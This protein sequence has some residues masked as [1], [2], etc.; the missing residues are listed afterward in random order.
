MKKQDGVL[1]NVLHKDLIVFRSNPNKLWE[2]VTII[3]NEAFK[4]VTDIKEIEIPGMVKEIGIRAFYHC[5]KLEKLVI[6]EGLQTIK[7]AAFCGCE[8]LKEVIL[9]EGIKQIDNTAFCACLRLE[10]I[11]VPSTVD[12]IS[13]RL[14]CNCWNLKKIILSQGLLKIGRASFDG[15]SKLENIEIPST[16]R[17]IDAYAFERCSKLKEIILPE[18]LNSIQ[19]CV[20]KGCTSLENVSIPESVTEIHEDAFAD[21]SRLKKMILP[22]SLKYINIKAFHN[23]NNMEE[24]IIP[25]NIKSVELDFYTNFNFNNIKYLSFLDDEDLTHPNGYIFS[26]DIPQNPH[27]IETKRI[28]ELVAFSCYDDTLLYKVLIEESLISLHDKDINQYLLKNKIKLPYDIVNKLKSEYRLD[29]FMKTTNFKSFRRIQKMIPEGL[30]SNNLSTFYT[31]AYNIGCFSKDSNLSNQA[32]TWLE[33]RLIS[34]RGKKPDLLFTEMHSKFASIKLKGENKEFSEFL[35]GKDDRKKESTFEELLKEENMIVTFNAIRDAYD[36]KSSNLKKGGRYRDEN[37]KLMFRFFRETIDENGNRVLKPKNLKPTIDVFKE[38]LWSISFDGIE[39]IEDQMI[40][41]ELSKWPGLTQKEFDDAKKIMREMNKK[42][43]PKNIVGKHLVD[44]TNEIEQYKKDT[45]RLAKAGL[46]EAQ[47]IVGKLSNIAN[48]DFTYEWLEKNDPLNFV[49]G[50]FCQ[51]CSSLSGV[52]YGIMKAS[53][54]HP[55]VQNLAI[56]DKKGTPIAKATIY[57]NRK[58]RYAVV[59]TFQVAMDMEDYHD[60]IYEEFMRGIE[61]F[62]EEYNKKYPKRQLERINVGIHYNHLEEQVKKGRQ[63]SEILE[64]IDFSKYGKDKQD[65]AG[66]WSEDQQYTLW[67]NKSIRRN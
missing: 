7:H 28:D 49:L 56:R 55:D 21:C 51:C 45:E 9:P 34:K 38:Y 20:F 19:H 52:G 35:F 40:A 36:D 23:C 50:L 37:G 46:K 22:K 16:V 59:N 15:C 2:N 60:L 24:L 63:P 12:F 3:G 39:T 26:K 18:G 64:A 67:E 30:D 43:I 29:E 57:V 4:A 61:A 14:F 62:A 47:E 1:T 41:K 25:A 17:K 48:K 33:A 65:Y 66:D 6:K 11:N 44:I 58:Q 13:D 10:K 32:C 8:S 5:D 27:V 42:R 53:F 31:F 54:V